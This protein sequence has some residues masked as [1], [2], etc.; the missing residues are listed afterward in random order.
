[1]LSFSV[2]PPAII[3]NF[4]WDP[5]IDRSDVVRKEGKILNTPLLNYEGIA[6]CVERCCAKRS[7][8]CI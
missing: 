7:A 2:S 6:Q 3:L 5:K 1:V 4:F 8:H